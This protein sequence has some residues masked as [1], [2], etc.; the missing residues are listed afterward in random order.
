VGYGC[1]TCIGNSGPLI[2]A[3]SAAVNEH[4]L[5]ACSVLSG[6]RNFEGRIHP[7][8]K[9]NFLTSPPLVIAYALAGTMH[10]DLLREPLG[11]D[12]DG[13]PVYLRDIWPTTAEIKRVVDYCVEAKMFTDGYADVVASDE[14]WRGMQTSSSEM[15]TWDPASTY[16]RR[17][18]CFDGMPREPGRVEDVGGAR[19][20]VMVG[21][22]VTTDHISPAGAIK[23]DSPAGRYLVEHGVERKDFNSYG[24]RRGNHEVMVRGTFANVRLRNLLVPDSEGTWTAHLPDGEEMTI[25]DAAERYRAEG[26]PLVVLAGKEYGSGSS[27]DWAA[28]GPNLLG[29]RA[30]IAESYERIHRSNLIGM[31]IVPLQYPDGESAASLGLTGREEFAVEGLENCEAREARV[32]ARPDSG[33]P[34]VFSARVRL[35]TP[36][37]RDYLQHGGI[38]LYALRKLAV[39]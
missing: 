24:S 7:Q 19:C 5:T 16:V 22:S 34:I 14:K 29:V 15:F 27:R 2:P 12:R 13:I 9:M 26:V 25:F 6:N 11:T 10:A 21:D 28:K 1:T 32:T 3:V 17:P 31:G 35:D 30:V 4:D 20:L 38:L 23:P 8:T 18:P 36:R 37:E 39:G 33:E